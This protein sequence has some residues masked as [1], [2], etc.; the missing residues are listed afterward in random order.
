MQ[1][2]FE[3][4]DGLKRQITA[5]MP[6]E[7]V[8]EL[9]STE[10]K[11]LSKQVRLQGFRPGKA[12]VKMV[13]KMYKNDI[14]GRILNDAFEQ[15]FQQAAQENEFRLAGQPSIT[16]VK[17][18][19]DQPLELTAEFEVYPEIEP[20]GIDG[21]ELELIESSVKDENLDEMIQ[22]LQKQHAEY[23]ETEEA[24][25]DNDRVLIDFTG[26]IDGEAFE[27]GSGEEMTV[28]V[29]GGQMIKDFDDGLRGLKAGEEKTISV[30]FPED[31]PAEQLQGKTAEFAIKCHKVE[32]P[33][34]PEVN[35]EFA[36]KFGVDTLEQFQKDLLSNMN[37]ELA[38]RVDA[39]NKEVIL[40]AWLE[41]N[42]FDVPQA[43]IDQE[44]DVL[45]KDMGI[46][47]APGGTDEQ[48]HKTMLN[49]LFSER[50]AKRVGLGLLMG[51]YISKEEIQVDESLMEE[52]LENISMSY[53]DPEE[54]KQHYRQ[55]P[56]ARQNLQALILEEQVVQKLRDQASVTTQEKPF[57]E[58]MSEQ[59]QQG[60]M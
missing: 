17:L 34:M 32:R 14:N 45:A 43:L 18:E 48:Q 31:Y 58:L 44:V 25:Q 42:T 7:T 36:Q 47:E 24:A 15:A 55:D 5:T 6:A 54:V 59:Q 50:A 21:V 41:A 13:Q 11:K 16:D 19:D 9:R 30:S 8:N 3:Q 57:T 22:R 2:S 56:Q 38:D 49:T 20:V 27:G 12:P 53:Q 33:D 52:K 37:R 10:A 23:H 29:G 1:V 35:D 40:D 39:K 60:R 28:E 26:T 4:L 51:A 46:Q